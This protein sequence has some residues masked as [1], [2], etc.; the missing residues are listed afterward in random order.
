MEQLLVVRSGDRW[1]GWRAA[2]VAEVFAPPAVT[3]LPETLPHLLGAIFHRGRLVTVADT[4]SL[5]GA[6]AAEGAPRLLVRLAPP[7]EHLAFSLDSVEAVLPYNALDLREEATDGL[8]SGLYPWGERWIP[9]LR[10]GAAA[11][12]LGVAAGPERA[13]GEDGEAHGR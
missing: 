11:A 3:P 7:R 1:M 10:A 6:A 4:V 13:P 9:V 5:V 12:A 8:W 2:E